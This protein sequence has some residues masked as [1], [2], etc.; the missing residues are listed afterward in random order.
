[1]DAISEIVN[2]QREFFNSG[3][4]KDVKFRI[5]MLN[6]LKQAVLNYE[7]RIMDA[8]F[9]DLNKDA[10]D[11]YTTEIGFVLNEISYAARKLPKWAKRKRVR[12]DI[13][14]FPAKSFIY[15][16]PYGVTLIIS[17]WNYPFQL[18]I[19]PLVGSIAAGNCAVIKPS[20][21]SPNTSKVL[22]Q[23]I[24][25]TF[26]E[27]YVCVIEG[28]REANKALL[29]SKFD[30]IFFT[31]SV[32]VGKVVME[33]AA[34]HLT[35]VTLEL[36]GKSPCIVDET[37]NLD[38]AA[39]RII[40]GKLINVGQ[41]CVAP[42]YLLVHSSVKNELVEKMKRVVEDFYGSNP[43][44]NEGYTKI[45]NEKHFNRLLG[46]VKGE[47]VIYGGEFDEKRLKINPCF[48][49]NASWNSPVMQEEIF[50]PVLPIIEF[51]NL[52]EVI[53]RI[54]QRPKPLALYYFTTSKD[55]E[56]KVLNSVSFGGGCINDTIMHLVSRHMPFGG[57]GESGMGSYHGRKSFDTFTH[58][59]S[60]LRKSNVID[61]PLRYPN[62]KNLKLVKKILK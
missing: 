32:S 19:A 43:V 58:Y 15:P 4:T 6:K 11:S 46:L 10:F 33:S 60:I 25:D 45:I 14:S 31:G 30:Y 16:E 62:R 59:K 51:E 42:D 49:D 17:P 54:K 48:I 57:V 38:L 2:K 22:K 29:D 5:E 28:G 23:L 8:L 50:G 39:K 47:K 3:R 20:S 40:W 26:D 34:K 56:E 7:D 37:A 55:R 36:G 24:E 53:E 13:A 61:V 41:T 1:M 18:A 21:Y 12:T 52:E 27:E 44:E 35:P 9:T